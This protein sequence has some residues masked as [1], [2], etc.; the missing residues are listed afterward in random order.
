MT[1]R[2]QEEKVMDE[3]FLDTKAMAK[4][5]GV[6]VRTLRRWVR[7]GIVPV[8]PINS[9]TWRYDVSAVREALKARAGVEQQTET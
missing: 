9:R 1:L 8:M 3:K 2:A 7:Q 6:C 4:Q 5:L